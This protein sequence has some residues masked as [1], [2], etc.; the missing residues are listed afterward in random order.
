[1]DDPW[2]DNPNQDNPDGD[3]Y[4]HWGNG[5]GGNGQPAP[6]PPPLTWSPNIVPV[7]INPMIFTGVNMHSSYGFGTGM[8]ATVSGGGSGGWYSGIRNYLED[9]TDQNVMEGNV[10]AAY[11]DQIGIEAID[12][13]LPQS[14]YEVPLMLMPMGKAGKYGMGEI[15]NVLGA[16]SNGTFR[17][18]STS[19][20]Y[21]YNKHGIG[22][23]I[24]SYTKDAVE[25]LNINKTIARPHLLRTGEEGLK[26][27]LSPISVFIQRK[28]KL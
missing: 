9:R 20:R 10:G 15:R 3:P 5:G 14:A 28:G 18:A 24:A 13:L 21:H 27:R 4:E 25:F 7:N 23:G 19:I 1:M 12:L 16:W 8:P 26:F 17:S 6:P 2:W 22:Q 11:I